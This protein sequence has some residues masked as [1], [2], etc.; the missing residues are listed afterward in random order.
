MAD[1][2]RR[3]GHGKAAIFGTLAHRLGGCR[4]SLACAEMTT[5]AGTNLYF[6]GAN[7]TWDNA[8]TKDWAPIPQRPVTSPLVER[9]RQLAVPNPAG[10]VTVSG[11]IASVESRTFNV[12]G[13]MLTGG[14]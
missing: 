1:R 7:P 5:A 6:S 12:S 8:T 9:V 13:Y 3:A 4:D 2:G 10:T 14:T 11:S